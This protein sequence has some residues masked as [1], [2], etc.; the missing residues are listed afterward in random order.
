MET[1]L[2][3]TMLIVQMGH[4][5]KPFPLHIITSIPL[6]HNLLAALWAVCFAHVQINLIS[7]LEL[8]ASKKYNTD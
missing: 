1:Y 3:I 8:C 6:A 5:R 2:S 4:K 7:R